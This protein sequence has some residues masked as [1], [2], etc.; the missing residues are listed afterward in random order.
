MDFQLPK[1]RKSE[2]KERFS[3]LFQSNKNVIVRCAILSGM[4]ITLVIFRSF[5]LGYDIPKFLPEENP[6]AAH[7]SLFTRV[8]IL[9]R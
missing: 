8:R 6:I 9:I 1:I 3:H 2:K 5:L 7:P 4:M